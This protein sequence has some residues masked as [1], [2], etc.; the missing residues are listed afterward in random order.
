MLNEMK[1]NVALGLLEAGAVK[2]GNFR[3]KLHEKQPDAPLSP[4]YV[5]LRILR[6]IP[7]MMRHCVSVYKDMTA[8][9][10]CDYYADV[11]TAGTPFVA[12]LAY[13][14]GT[15]MISPR[16][17]DK[18]HGVKRKIDG[19]FRQG[20]VALLI[21]DLITKADSKLEAIRILEENGLLVRDVVVLVDREQGGGEELASRGY[22]CHSAFRL[23]DLLK[24]YREC[25]SITEADF[26][27][28]M[29]YL[30]LNIH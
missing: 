2:F 29:Q 16:L 23:G 19:V 4:I 14:T 3:L 8:G 12:A 9:L 26:G 15:P 5:D 13:E 25:G 17:D 21:D 11:P 20:Q 24:F 27:R 6:S 22:A 10:Q 7:Q 18:T 28:T 1:R 30:G